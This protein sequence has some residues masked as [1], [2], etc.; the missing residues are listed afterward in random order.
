MSTTGQY[1][2]SQMLERTRVSLISINRIDECT[3]SVP[4]MGR[5][6][7]LAPL[8]TGMHPTDLMSLKDA[9]L[10]RGPAVWYHSCKFGGNRWP[11]GENSSDSQRAVAARGCERGF[12]AD[13]LISL[14]A[15][16]VSFL[17]VP[18]SSKPFGSCF[19]IFSKR[20]YLKRNKRIPLSSQ[21][22]LK[23]GEL[24]TPHPC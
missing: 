1:S 9:G 11:H 12:W 3:A 7:P 24:K 13:V 8:I 14:L 21:D 2:I 15:A 5:D 18:R 19:L 23:H 22:W 10:K 16:R 4:A 20:G 6:A 17:C